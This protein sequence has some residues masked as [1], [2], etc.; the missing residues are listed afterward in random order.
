MHIVIYKWRTS[1]HFLLQHLFP[2]AEIIQAEPRV[3]DERIITL[4]HQI[5][6]KHQGEETHWFFQINLSYSEKWLCNRVGTVQV[7]MDLGFHVYNSDVTDIRKRSL[8]K[9]IRKTGLNCVTVDKQDS[10]AATPVIVKTNYNYGGEFESTLSPE[11]VRALDFESVTGCKIQSSV[12]Y[13]RT[14][15]AE[16]DKAVWQDE[17]LVVERCIENSDNRFYRFYRCGKNAILSEIINENLIKKMEPGLPRKN[18]YFEFRKCTNH[19]YQELIDNASTLLDEMGMKFGAVDIV[20]DDKGRAYIIDVNP[21]PGW[22]GENQGK[23]L[24]F[25]RSGVQRTCESATDSRNLSY[26]EC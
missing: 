15:L 10:E 3:D 4:A 21:T 19:I 24:R 17:R 6:N 16:V 12:G 22:G 25:L 1:H 14:T 18:W 11:L 7:L 2:E 26:E 20:M 8:Q 9:L 23:I 5:A 13:Y